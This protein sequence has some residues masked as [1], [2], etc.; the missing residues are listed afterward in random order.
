MWS[1]NSAIPLSERRTLTRCRTGAARNLERISRPLPPNNR[2]NTQLTQHAMADTLE[3]VSTP[4]SRTLNFQVPDRQPCTVE[5]TI[6]PCDDPKRY[7]NHILFPE[8]P[9][10]KFLGFPVANAKV[11]SPKSRGYAAYYGWMQVARDVPELGA[12][13]KSEW[14]MDP[15]PVHKDCNTPFVFF[16]PEPQLFDMPSRTE[17]PVDSLDWE[18]RS[19]LCYLED[20]LL[21]KV[22]RPILAVQWGFWIVD[23]KVKVKKAKV[24]DVGDAWEECK[25]RFETEFPGWKFLQKV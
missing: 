2:C 4:Q 23:G 14:H 22:V 20:G 21:T 19:Y 6:E 9:L 11:H 15:V 24:V 7:G 5:F 10:S 17:P 16:G 1:A 12:V 13:G 3:E 18:A 25:G 8:T